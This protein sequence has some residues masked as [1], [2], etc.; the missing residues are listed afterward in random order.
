MEALS[1]FVLFQIAPDRGSQGGGLSGLV[2]LLLFGA[3]FYFMMRSGC[4]A[5]MV[6]G[7]HGDHESGHG[8]PGASATDP[9]CGMEV[10]P[11]KGYA[12]MYEG[13]E[14]RF[15]SR[16]CLDKFDAE[17]ARY[18]TTTA[19]GRDIGE[20]HAAHGSHGAGGAP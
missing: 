4:G 13:R 2:T 14:Y 9:V 3:F 18:L 11:E 19:P 17:P 1:T 5:H 7:G 6:H 8:G 16:D 10:A 12:R 15:C 20:S